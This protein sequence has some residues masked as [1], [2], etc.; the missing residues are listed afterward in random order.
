MNPSIRQRLLWTLLSAT[1][2][3]WAAT[4]IK[5]Y[6]DNRYEIAELFDAQLAQSARALLTLSSHELYEQLAYIA[7]T[8]GK[9]HNIPEHI[10]PQVHKYE[11]HLA[12]QIWSG[13]GR[14][15]A[16]S[17]SAPTDPLTGA[18]EIFSDHVING[19]R[20]RVYALVDAE[21][22]L[23]VQVGERY[24]QREQLSDDVA[25]RLL[26]AVVLS[27]P[28]LA[29]MIWFGVSYAIR[30]LKRVTRAVAARKLDN[31]EPIDNRRVPE[32][33]RPL[34]DAL[35]DLFVRLQSA[36]NDIL[37]FT[38][39]AAHELRTPLAALKTHAQVALRADDA[40][41][42]TEALHELIHGVDRA[43]SL[44]EQLLT[45]ARLDPEAIPL[46]NETADLQEIAQEVLSELATDAVKKEIDISLDAR[47]R[48]IV[49]GKQVMLTIL[50]R[51]LVENAIR[52]TPRNGRVEVSLFEDQQAM[53]LRV[54]D[55]GAGIPAEEREKIFK[56]FYRVI[57]N[58]APGSGLGLSIVQRIV[59]I[60]RAQIELGESKFGGLKFDVRL[61]TAPGVAQE[62]T[63]A[64]RA[65]LMQNY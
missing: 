31:L 28:V 14:L 15:V 23:Q 47:C 30:P 42:R 53:V 26:A 58:G 37:H 9:S 6:Y 51:N 7:Q 12:F 20:W 1:L 41:T 55:S 16:R 17:D 27:L 48:G 56:R 60:H 35:N 22:N 46:S 63:V 5:N 33:T 59:E 36:L 45:L 10:T 13:D 8:Q 38:A 4:A 43:T 34:V 65:L 19:Q 62:F 57:G 3:V 32:E 21:K 50:L 24:L 39:D 54:A 2:V 25:L 64:E 49:T 44:V 52:Y 61:H 29:L 11:Q 40:P 18:P